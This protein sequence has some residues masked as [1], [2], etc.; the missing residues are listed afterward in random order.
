MRR[1]MWFAI[2][3]AAACA[4]GGYLVSG[5]WLLLLAL[6]CLGAV[7]SL[8]FVKGEYVRIARLAAIGCLAG[9]LWFWVFDLTYLAPAREYDAQ[10]VDTSVTI[11][12]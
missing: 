3:F 2:G 12:D 6:F 4:V 5:S 9:F 1:L 7:I 10:T 11:V 8:F